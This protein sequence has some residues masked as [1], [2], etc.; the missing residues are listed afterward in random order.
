MTPESQA[1]KPIFIVASK[2]AIGKALWSEAH[3]F[4][5]FIVCV[6]PHMFLYVYVYVYCV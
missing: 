2:N 4:L 5:N 1:Q 3:R 6:S